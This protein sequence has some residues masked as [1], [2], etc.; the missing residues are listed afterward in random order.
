[1]ETKDK[2]L[3]SETN[4]MEQIQ[5]S[6]PQIVVIRLQAMKILKNLQES[7]M[8]LE[9]AAEEINDAIEALSTAEVAMSSAHHHLLVSHTEISYR[10]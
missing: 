6:I 5:K 7:G 3:N 1:M 8:Q 2:I 9:V 4:M 10:G